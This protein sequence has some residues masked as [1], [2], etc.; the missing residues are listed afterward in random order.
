MERSERRREREMVR[1][2]E[3]VPVYDDERIIER[4][5]VYGERRRRGF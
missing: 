3:V 4:E 5:V 1:E 2:R